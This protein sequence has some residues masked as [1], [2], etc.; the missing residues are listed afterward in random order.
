MKSPEELKTLKEEVESLNKKLAELS[1]EELEQVAG[2]I[3]NGRKYWHRSMD[4][5]DTLGDGGGTLA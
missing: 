1:R 2:G 3:A 5:S 4:T